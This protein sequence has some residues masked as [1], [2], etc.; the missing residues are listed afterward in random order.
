M[1]TEL[2]KLHEDKYKNKEKYFLFS[3]G[4]E[5]YQVLFLGIYCYQLR[6]FYIQGKVATVATQLY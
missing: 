6:I 4:L 1:N 2:F 3:Y 5:R